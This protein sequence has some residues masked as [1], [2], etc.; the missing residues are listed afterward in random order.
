MAKEGVIVKT[1]ETTWMQPR[2]QTTAVNR[3][4]LGQQKSTWT[5]TGEFAQKTVFVLRPKLSIGEFM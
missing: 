3:V 5:P 2:K 4:E 1:T